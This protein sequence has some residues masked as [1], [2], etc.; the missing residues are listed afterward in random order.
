MFY[1]NKFFNSS[2]EELLRYY[3]RFY[4]GIFEMREMLKAQGRLGDR[5]EAGVEQI[6]A[7]S[8]IETADE[9]TIASM[10]KFLGIKLRK[11]STL[12]ER[13]R[14][15]KSYFV[16]AGKTS[17]TMIINMI[18]AYTNA[19]VDVRFEPSDEAGNNT[20][21]IEF[22]RGSEKELYLEDIAALVSAK[23]PAHIH[24]E[25]NMRY[26]ERASI[27]YGAALQTGTTLTLGTEAI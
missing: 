15:V 23:I 5:L 14:I 18:H 10:E 16:G 1:N 13:R 3:P 27:F 19:E 20:L 9:A 7:N 11:V 25:L 22:D 12:E 4:E 21:Y 24:Y 17:A 2:Y 6:V 8:Y 26:G